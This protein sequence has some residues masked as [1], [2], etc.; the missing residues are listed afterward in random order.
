MRPVREQLS[1]S[2]NLSDRVARYLV[3]HIRRNRLT[4]G[5]AIPSEIRLSAQLDVS[6]GIV[7]EAYRSLGT[8][9]ILDIANG[10]PPRVGRLSNR[11][12]RQFLQH[13]LSTE[14]ASVEQVFD[15]RSSLEVRAAELAAERRSDEDAEA[16]V[17]EVADVAELTVA[18]Q[19]RQQLLDRFFGIEV[20]S[21]HLLA[22][23]H[24][25]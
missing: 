23:Q 9:G 5:A 17:Q 6:R 22:R 3:D 8:A 10:R 24:Q 11:A 25:P 16:L 2:G 15:V 20:E 7:R 4:S 12:F 19:S 21:L 18:E 14:Q 13:A 1:A